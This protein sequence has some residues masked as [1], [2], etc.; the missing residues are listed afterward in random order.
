MDDSFN[1]QP[2]IGAHIDAGVFSFRQILTDF[3]LVIP[4]YQREYRWSAE[5]VSMFLA[6]AFQDCLVGGVPK[7]Y[8]AVTWSKE[9][10]ASDTRNVV[11]GQQRTTT[12]F[13]LVAAIR[14]R[15]EDYGHDQKSIAL[16][17]SLL[18]RRLTSQH[19]KA[20]L[21]IE[22]IGK[23]E[24]I[25]GSK[26]VE[27]SIEDPLLR[28]ALT[29]LPGVTY[30]TFYNLLYKE[31]GDLIDTYCED[32]CGEDTTLDSLR[33]QAVKDFLQAF[34]DRA[35]LAVVTVVGHE[36]AV[37]IFIKQHETLSPL[38]DFDTLKGALFGITHPDNLRE[39][40]DGFNGIQERLWGPDVSKAKSAEKTLHYVLLGIY[41]GAKEN[42]STS[43]VL[44]WAKSGGSKKPA[45]SFLK[46]VLIPGFEALEAATEKMTTPTGD[47]SE[48][49]VHIMSTSLKTFRQAYPIIVAARGLK[50][51][52]F[53]KVMGCLRDTLIV[54]LCVQ[55]N[56]NK[57]STALAAMAR[58]VNKGEVDTAVE[59]MVHF[60]RESYSES[61][62]QEF[63]KVGLYYPRTSTD[64]KNVVRLMLLLAANSTPE[65]GTLS[66]KDLL[67]W[68]F[69][70]GKMPHM[71]WHVEHIFPQSQAWSGHNFLDPANQKHRL[72]NLTMLESAVNTS[73][74]DS[75]F[76]FKKSAYKDSEFTLT[77]SL[78]QLFSCWGFEQFATRTTELYNIFVSLFA[79]DKYD[80]TT[81]TNT[82]PPRHIRRS[83]LPQL[84]FS[85]FVGFMKAAATG[86]V[87]RRRFAFFAENRDDRQVD[88]FLSFM[89]AAGLIEDD[90]SV[91][92]RGRQEIH[93]A[94]DF[95]ERWKRASEE[96]GSVQERFKLFA[97]A[98]ELGWGGTVTKE[99]VV[100][101]FEAVR[102]ERA[103]GSD[104]SYVGVRTEAI[105]RA[106]EA[107]NTMKWD[108]AK[109][110][111]ETLN[112]ALQ[113]VYNY[114]YG[115][116]EAYNDLY[117][118]ID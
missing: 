117:G 18:A 118:K 34:L 12:A 8:G 116:E 16:C 58:A 105:A 50:L 28:A 6:D 114:L 100:E 48:P 76:N 106:A 115:M 92:T 61:F 73:I 86:E 26:K 55:G 52:E 72:G 94:E 93:V 3:E 30:W 62:S 66:W 111:G 99:V 107:L 17:N 44:A 36:N 7:F 110:N 87:E 82:P 60:R 42:P 46:D 112:R 68:R 59:D 14:A 74:S 47:V 65:S 32:R 98:R 29:S 19:S 25:P 69:E 104:T 85:G 79:L 91:K 108:G 37:K 10:D 31:L 103:G 88:Y 22:A 41:D 45:I 43:D 40:A 97:E 101:K 33:A 21:V 71:K 49:L 51:E 96:V 23:G 57:L 38:D 109:I 78:P 80:M 83:C 64:G 15:L 9:Q 75:S 20:Q 35:G 4:A 13:L 84:S 39:L 95:V 24:L 53:N 54:A 5:Q 2:A 89:D 102:S 70:P 56:P 67:D 81:L 1:S 90:G 113:E 77:N 11:D 27:S 63:P